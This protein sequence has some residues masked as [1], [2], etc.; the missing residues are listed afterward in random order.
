MLA[1]TNMQL[2]GKQHVCIRILGTNFKIYRFKKKFWLFL[3]LFKYSCLHF[4]IYRFWPSII[5]ALGD[6]LTF[7]HETR[8]TQTWMT[9]TSPL[10]DQFRDPIGTDSLGLHVESSATSFPSSP[11]AVFLSFLKA[12]LSALRCYDVL[13]D[14]SP[15]SSQIAGLWINL[16]PFHEHLSHE[17]GVVDA[18]NWTCVW[19]YFKVIFKY[20]VYIKF[21]F[22]YVY[23]NIL[24]P[25]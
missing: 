25:F 16:C 11:C 6:L 23:V 7:N 17:L 13:W 24:I 1:L 18:S 9:H 21:I 19:L 14:K 3:L 15:P 10:L 22:E 20:I 5:W 12:L 8:M 4:K 2:V